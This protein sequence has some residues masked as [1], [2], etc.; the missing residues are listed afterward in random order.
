MDSSEEIKEC[1]NC[2][3]KGKVAGTL[4]GD[5]GHC[6]GTGRAVHHDDIVE[7][8]ATKRRGRIDLTSTSPVYWRVQF[9]D[10][11]EPPFQL[12]KEA[13]IRLV[14]CPHTGNRESFMYPANPIM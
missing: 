9:S 4:G 12:V 3:G 2:H 13:E 14:G 5:C 6:N 1:G 7:V 8:V 11:Q 10:G